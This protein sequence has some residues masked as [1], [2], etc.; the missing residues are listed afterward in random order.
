MI[1]AMNCFN[2]CLAYFRITIQSVDEWIGLREKLQETPIISYNYLMGTSM[3]SCRFPLSQ[4]IGSMVQ[5]VWNDLETHPT[6]KRGVRYSSN[7]FQAWLRP[8]PQKMGL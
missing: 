5:S 7:L 4:S 1:N 6:E 8:N 3:V 2:R